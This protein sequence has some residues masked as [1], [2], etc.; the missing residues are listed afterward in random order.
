MSEEQEFVSGKFAD[1]DA[2]AV[3]TIARVGNQVFTEVNPVEGF[4]L[5]EPDEMIGAL[6]KAISEY[7][8]Y[9]TPDFKDKEKK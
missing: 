3:I 6:A 8:L 4:G 9:V 7:V 5:V 2:I 1:A